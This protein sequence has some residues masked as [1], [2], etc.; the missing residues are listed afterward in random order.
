LLALLPFAP[1]FGATT[2]V[3]YITDGDNGTIQAIQGNAIIYENTSLPSQYNPGP[4]LYAI[5]VRDTVWLAS[6]HPGEPGR[7][8][9]NK[10]LNLTGN[11]GSVVLIPSGNETLD[12][13]MDGNYNYTIDDENGDIYRYNADWSG[14]PVLVFTSACNGDW[15]PGITYDPVNDSFWTTDDDNIYE[16]STAGELRGSFVHGFSTGGLA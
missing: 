2:D 9:L 4:T 10:S 1:A 3:L 7:L 8:E 15:C 6:Y 16:Y 12:G 13:A 11:S 5:A 14:T